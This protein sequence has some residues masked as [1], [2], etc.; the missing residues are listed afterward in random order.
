MP[1]SVTFSEEAERKESLDLLPYF[2]TDLERVRDGQKKFNEIFERSEI[3][4]KLSKKDRY[5]KSRMLYG[6]MGLHPEVGFYWGAGFNDIENDDEKKELKRIYED[7]LGLKVLHLP[8][9]TVTVIN[10]KSVEKV[11]K[12][13]PIAE[14]F[15]KNAQADPVGWVETNPEEWGDNRVGNPDPVRRA[16]FGVLSGYPPNASS[17][18]QKYLEAKKILDKN[19]SKRELAPYYKYANSP[20][21][22]RALSKIFEKKLNSIVNSKKITSSQA[23]L[24]KNWFSHHANELEYF[25]DGFSD[26]DAEYFENIKKL[27]NAAGVD[28]THNIYKND[29]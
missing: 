28:Y 29:H 6:A 4:K 9:S 1:E 5:F 20:R 25:G 11:I 13:C 17:V 24:L 15:P 3:L 7:K 2:L 18:Y 27:L 8:D 14:L 22:S 23:E 26:K 10:P 21:E 16:R 19:L 12:N